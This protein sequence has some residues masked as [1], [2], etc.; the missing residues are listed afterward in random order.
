M[1][2]SGDNRTVDLS[3][4]EE[5][6]GLE[7][8]SGAFMMGGRQW[9]PLWRFQPAQRMEDDFRLLEQAAPQELRCGQHPE[10]RILGESPH[11]RYR[12]RSS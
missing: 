1:R 11:R 10:W 6:H 4:G 5:G 12:R 9:Q 2:P 7:G 3:L 8:R